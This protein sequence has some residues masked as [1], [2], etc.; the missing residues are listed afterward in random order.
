ML[1]GWS[2]RP[3]GRRYARRTRPSRLR[4]TAGVTDHLRSSPAHKLESPTAGGGDH[5][6]TTDPRCGAPARALSYPAAL[7]HEVGG[8][9]L[10]TKGIQPPPPE[11]DG[12]VSVHPALQTQDLLGV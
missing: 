11:P 10:V 7:V 9:P 12:H 4:R 6:R 3:G 2:P 5:A 1:S 8:Q